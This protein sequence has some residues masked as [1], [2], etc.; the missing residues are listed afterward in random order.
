MFNTGIN[1]NLFELIKKKV[2]KL[3]EIEKYCVLVW[4]EMALKAQLQYNSGK[5]LIDGF[6]DLSFIRRPVFATHAL[7]FMVLGIWNHFKQ[8]VA[9]Y[10]THGLKYFELTEIVQ[11][12]IGALQDQGKHHLFLLSN[13]C[14][15]QFKFGHLS[16]LKVIGSI[17]DQD[18]ANA[19]GINYLVDPN[20][21]PKDLDG[22]LLIY[23]INGSNVVHCFDPPHLIKGIRNNLLT[24]DLEHTISSRWTSSTD[25]NDCNT[26]EFCEVNAAEWSGIVELYSINSKASIPLLEKIHDEHINPSKNKMKVNLATQVFSQTFGTL[27]LNFSKESLLSRDFSST[28]QLLLF[29][30]DLFDSLNGFG[31]CI[32]GSLKGS[33]NSKSAHFAFWEYAL[34]MLKQM[35][36][37]DKKKLKESKRSK[38][39]FKYQST[40]KGYIEILRICFSLNMSQVSLR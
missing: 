3:P 10:Y 22:E 1:E 12:V 28:A 23:K 31:A 36:W 25:I 26:D 7:T 20:L 21:K 37:F 32:S 17:C 19:K 30:N 16:G 39:L 35:A 2:Q 6:V 15:L 38:V 29:Y 33:V 11:L 4:D 40:I 18:G 9:F 34:F 5:D 27:M 14:F 8:P 24:K 13:L